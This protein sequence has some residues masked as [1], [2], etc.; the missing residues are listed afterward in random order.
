MLKDKFVEKYGKA[1]TAIKASGNEKW[2]KSV[3]VTTTPLPDSQAISLNANFTYSSYYPFEGAKKEG[4]NYVWSSPHGE[5]IG[6]Q[7]LAGYAPPK[8]AP[9]VCLKYLIN[10]DVT[11]RS[12]TQWT[13]SVREDKYPRIAFL[14]NLIYACPCILK[15]MTIDE[16]GLSGTVLLDM[17]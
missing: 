5:S 10:Y 9:Y 16:K 3:T 12:K 4:R 15:D 2:I 17:T 13:V 11:E 1:Q 14:L 7:D 6:R 8:T